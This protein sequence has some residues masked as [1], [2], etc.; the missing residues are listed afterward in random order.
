MIPINKGNNKSS[1]FTLLYTLLGIGCIAVATISCIK[2]PLTMKGCSTTKN[3]CDKGKEEGSKSTPDNC[4][5][6]NEILFSFPV[7]CINDIMLFPNS[8]FSTIIKLIMPDEQASLRDILEFITR[9]NLK[10]AGDFFLFRD[11]GSGGQQELE[12]PIRNMQEI[13][14]KCINN[15]IKNL[16]SKAMQHK[17]MTYGAYIWRFN[18]EKKQLHF[19]IAKEL[20]KQGT[21]RISSEEEKSLPFANKCE[22]CNL[23]NKMEPQLNHL[24]SLLFQQEI[25]AN[26]IA[27][28]LCMDAKQAITDLDNTGIPCNIYRYEMPRNE[29]RE[30]CSALTTQSVE[31]VT[32]QYVKFLEACMNP[33]VDRKIPNLTKILEEKNQ[34]YNIDAVCKEIGDVFPTQL[35]ITQTKNKN[36]TIKTKNP[37]AFKSKSLSTTLLPAIDQAEQSSNKPLFEQIELFE[38]INLSLLPNMNSL[39]KRVVKWSK[40]M[41]WLTKY[42][43][44]AEANSYDGQFKDK[45]KDLATLSEEKI[46]HDITPIHF[47]LACADV[48]HYFQR[49]DDKDNTRTAFIMIDNQ[50]IKR[51]G[52]V[53]IALADNII[54]HQAIRFPEIVEKTL[55]SPI[56]S[57][58][59]IC[60]DTEE[61]YQY[62]EGR[63]IVKDLTTQAYI[64]RI[65]EKEERF[66]K[67]I[68]VFPFRIYR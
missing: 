27:M 44:K 39:D 15:K 20:K 53:D 5:N 16:V 57:T 10:S 52:M 65:K 35:N 63:S 46:K 64:V 23:M 26:R 66:S 59:E 4:C 54:Y 51:F 42:Y 67:D 17:E 12:D 37:I 38:Q 9:T 32:E 3:Q 50:L 40:N 55:H 45:N 6:K 11:R 33:A 49:R 19:D 31:K 61:A 13:I 28:N 14:N 48:D 24:I 47:L 68:H 29:W 62:I 34:A 41:N 1:Y 60:K 18:K 2:Q 58:T 25:I 56:D 8:K 36:K 7:V 43:Q 21:R 22:E 30:L